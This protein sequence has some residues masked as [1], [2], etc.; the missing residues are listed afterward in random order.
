MRY[1]YDRMPASGSRLCTL[2]HCNGC[3]HKTGRVS[4]HITCIAAV[5]AYLDFYQMGQALHAEAEHACIYMD[6]CHM[7]SC[8]EGNLICVLTCSSV[9]VHKT[10]TCITWGDKQIGTVDVGMGSI[11]PHT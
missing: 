1:L 9:D 10:C 5:E 8:L 3:M 4:G 2:T 6:K 7:R 11:C